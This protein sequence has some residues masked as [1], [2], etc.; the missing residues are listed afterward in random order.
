MTTDATGAG[1]DTSTDA[2]GADTTS[3]HSETSGSPNEGTQTDTDDVAKWKALARKHE[4]QAKANADAAKRL[5]EI[6]DAGK[7]EQERLSEQL[8]IA[9]KERD[10]AA[11]KLTRYEVA[12][13]KSLPQN[14][15]A[16]LTGSTR[17]EIEASADA[18]L[19]LLQ[20]KG[21]PKPVGSLGNNSGNS[22][23]SPAQEFASFLNAQ[24]R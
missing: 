9:A 10:E 8:A 22:G 3:E 7:T 6:E 23:G 1:D 12:A 24:L 18:L 19:E 5:Q 16:L 21:T 2:S 14:A 11:G 20:S 13:D 4:A 17:E 15:V